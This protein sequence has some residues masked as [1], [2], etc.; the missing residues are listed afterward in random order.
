[1]ATEETSMAAGRHPSFLKRQKE[2]KRLER[3]NAKRIAR[4]A[5]RTEK[6]ARRGEDPDPGL[7]PPTPQDESTPT[8]DAESN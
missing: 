8:Q 4:Q 1:V 7:E 6:S 5:R 3:A 2:Q